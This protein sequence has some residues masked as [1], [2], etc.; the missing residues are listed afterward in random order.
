[1]Y[2]KSN[3]PLR[4]V[5]SCARTHARARSHS[6]EAVIGMHCWEGKNCVSLSMP[7]W[8]HTAALCMLMQTLMDLGSL[9][10]GAGVIQSLHSLDKMLHPSYYYIEILKHRK[11]RLK[12]PWSVDIYKWAMLAFQ[13]RWIYGLDFESVSYIL[14]FTQLSFSIF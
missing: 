7:L 6:A 14:A 10:G 13:T 12:L 3:Y 4:R 5:K 8:V 9:G 1:M 11:E 2:W